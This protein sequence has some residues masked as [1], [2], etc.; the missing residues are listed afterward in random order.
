MDMYVR[1]WA[2]EGE[3]GNGEPLQVLEQWQYGVMKLEFRFTMAY[4]VFA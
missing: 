4:F 3:S 2:E 1:A